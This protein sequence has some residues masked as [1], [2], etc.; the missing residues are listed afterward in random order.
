M[1]P[2]RT[3]CLALISAF[4][5]IQTHC[6]N[7]RGQN[8]TIELKLRS[9]QET[10]PGAG[11]FHRSTRTEN[12]DLKQTAVIVCDVWDSHHCVNAVRRVVEVAPRID[13]FVAALRERGVTVIHA[14][15]GCMDFYHDH[16]ARQHA[17]K[18]PKSSSIPSDIG[19]W[20]DQIPAEERAAYPLDQSKGGEDD[21]LDE[22]KLW[23]T[24]LAAE[25]RNPGSPW[26]RQIDVIR[27]DDQRDFITDRG[28]EVWSILDSRSIKN[29]ILTG[30]HTNMCV[31]GRPFGLRQM[32]THGKNTVLARDLTDTMYDPTQWPYVSHFTGTDIIVDHIERYVCATITSDQVLGG[33]PFRFSGDTRPRLAILMAEDEYKT[34]VSLPKFAA[35]H[36]G[37]HFSVNLIFGS[38]SQRNVVPGIEEIDHADVLLVSV[39]RRPLPEDDLR[40]IRKFVAAGKPVVG[41]R[42][43][44][45]AFSLR[46]QEPATGLAVWQEFDSQV[47]G[48]SYTNHYGNELHPVISTAEAGSKHPIMA[49]YQASEFVSSGSL[50]KVTPLHPGTQVLMTGKIPNELPQPVAWTYVRAD[51]GRSFYTSL[52][53][54]DDF[55]QPAFRQLL[56]NALLWT[57]NLPPV[58]EQAIR[59]ESDKYASGK[60]K[61]RK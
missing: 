61:Q 25:G 43:A 12:W 3:L 55:K 46:N 54:I 32:S 23:A 4:S 59:S 53:H 40:R 21:D 50:Y 35:E 27:I 15:S 42:T 22:H 16:P 45:H 1:R 37:K 60:G 33:R 20:C 10:A 11:R 30:V 5:F 8:S 36:L 14:P 41:I 44:S 34:E 2:A 39:R 47:L 7:S 17:I 26:K 57:C 58:N 56:T 13:R 18:V 52:G 24:R 49:N 48:G 6:Q 31:L 51:G 19:Q 28:D 29:V 9:Q 38:E